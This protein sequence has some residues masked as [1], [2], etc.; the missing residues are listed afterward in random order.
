MLKCIN[1]IVS[2]MRFIFNYVPLRGSVSIN[3][4]MAFYGFDFLLRTRLAL[5]DPSID[6]LRVANYSYG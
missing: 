3:S 4:E 5:L 6:A 2:A 1:D